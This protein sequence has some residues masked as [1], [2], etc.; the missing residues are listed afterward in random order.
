M[1]TLWNKKLKIH[2]RSIKLVH[3]CRYILF[4]TRHPESH[5]VPRLYGQLKIHKPEHPVWPVFASYT[6]PSFKLAKYLAKEFRTITSFAPPHCIQDSTQLAKELHLLRLPPTCRLI[7]FDAKSLFSNIPVMKTID[8]IYETL[9]KSGQSYQ[10]T[11]EFTGLVSS[12]VKQNICFAN[13][14]IHLLPDGLPMGGP[15]SSLMADIF[16]DRLERWALKSARFSSQVLLWF[17][18]VDDILCF[19]L[20]T[21][22]SSKSSPATYRNLMTIYRS[23]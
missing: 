19:W 11:E 3:P 1:Q 18:F 6:C 12:C 14:K 4:P 9:I 13:G 5:A 10:Y 17:R 23:Q 16:M 15:L 21:D 7:S 8:I 2:S 20:G 22:M